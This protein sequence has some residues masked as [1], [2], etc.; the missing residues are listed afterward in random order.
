[1]TRNVNWVDEQQAWVA[2]STVNLRDM[3][4]DGLYF[5]I[6]TAAKEQNELRATSADWTLRDGTR[7]LN[8]KVHD[9][10]RVVVEIDAMEIGGR[11][12]LLLRMFRNQHAF[13]ESFLEQYFEARFVR[14]S[15][16][17]EAVIKKAR[18]GSYSFVRP[19]ETESFQ[20]CG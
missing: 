1:M 10:S 20:L 17:P 2:T 16:R 6:R 13:M 19:E 15:V 11:M 3:D 4:A 18:P 7:R 9:G 8:V 12:L 14:T 5:A